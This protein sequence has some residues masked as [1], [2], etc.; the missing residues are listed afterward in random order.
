MALRQPYIWTINIVAINNLEKVKIMAKTHMV[1]LSDPSKV[2]SM[3]KV[4][5]GPKINTREKAKA[6]T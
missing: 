5:H 6:K 4:E 1:V 2:I 3:T